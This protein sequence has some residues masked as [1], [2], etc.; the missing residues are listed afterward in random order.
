MKS[1]L[2]FFLVIG[3]IVLISFYASDSLKKYFIDATNLVVGQIYSIASFV[4]DSFDEHFAQVRLI[5]ELKEQN[6][7]LEEK[8]SLSEAFS[9]ELSQVMRDI[10]SSFV[11]ES[12][13]VRALSYA[14][15]GDHSKI[16]LDFKEFDSNKIYGLLSDGK[17]AGIVINQN[18]RPLA[19]LQNDQKSMFAVYIGEE[20]IPGI[21]K[22]NGKNIEVKYIAKWLTPQVG[23]EVYTSG[24]DGIFFGG[25]AVGKVVELID[26]TIYITAVVEPAAD[27]KVP[28][29]LYVITKG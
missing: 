3:Y 10:N 4:K 25:I 9:Y 5:K 28:S 6:E 19:V 11:P 14:Q 17:T 26:E 12:R 7:K 16:W 24:L 8:A 29:Y 15:I 21:A 27:V 23:D 13:K 2:K 18:D 22:G 20:K 1:K